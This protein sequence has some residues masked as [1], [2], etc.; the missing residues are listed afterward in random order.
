MVG[1]EGGGAG[2]CNLIRE[3]VHLLPVVVTESS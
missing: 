2:D 3:L 1:K